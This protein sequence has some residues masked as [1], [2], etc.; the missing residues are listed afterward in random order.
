MPRNR[1]PSPQTTKVLAA[2]AADPRRW[3]YGY[4]LGAETE[5]KAGSLYP[6]LVRL[7]DRGF[8]E[9][10]WEE[11]PPQGARAP[12]VPADRGR[13]RAGRNGRNGRQ[14]GHGLAAVGRHRPPGGPVAA[15]R[16]LMGGV[17]RRLLKLLT[18][19]MPPSRRAF[20][21]A[22][23]AELDYVLSRRG[24]ARLV[25]G[26]VRVALLP[27]PELA[28]YG[29]AA[30]RAALVAA[31]GWIPLGIGQYLDN[32]VFA[33]RQDSSLGV[34]TMNAYLIVMLMTAGAVARRVAGGSGPRIVAGLAAGLVV[35]VLGMATFVVI[36]NAFLPIVMQQTAKIDGF[37]ASG[38]TSM[39]AYINQ[40]L[41]A[42][43]PG[44]A[45]F[46]AVIGVIFGSLGAVADR[47]IVVSRARRRVI[48]HPDQL[49]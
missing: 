33:D 42:T 10:R 25:V 29:R 30:G 23:I 16:C 32:V 8:L 11:A 5:L 49:R 37:R 14:V 1:I 38:L 35:A 26:A 44:L 31:V 20:G 6:I 43:A 18:A 19:L 45:V 21:Q 3:R 13:A 22:M 46:A 34:L 4:E 15:G 27:P 28:G 7:A 17:A 41:E 2:L 40:S 12:P 9:A 47:A 24:R 36:D 39:R 48:P